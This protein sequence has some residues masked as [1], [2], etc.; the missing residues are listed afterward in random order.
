MCKCKCVSVLEELRG[1]LRGE[2]VKDK[3]VCECECEFVSV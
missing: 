2:E 3:V 1:E